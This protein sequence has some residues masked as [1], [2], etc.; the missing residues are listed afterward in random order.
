MR[1][2]RLGAEG[3]GTEWN[4]APLEKKKRNEIKRNK[5]SALGE[6]AN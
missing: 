1:Q 6:D 3:D 2:M 4:Q 5:L